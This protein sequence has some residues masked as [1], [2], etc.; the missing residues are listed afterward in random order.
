V[1][2]TIQSNCTAELATMPEVV[3]GDKERRNAFEMVI[4]LDVNCQIPSPK[5]ARDKASD[6]KEQKYQVSAS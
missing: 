3:N 2:G 4:S 6:T 1:P 5:C